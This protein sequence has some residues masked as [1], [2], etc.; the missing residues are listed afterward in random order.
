M[1]RAWWLDWQVSQAIT[2]SCCG[3]C[4]LVTTQLCPA[5][6]FSGQVNQ[7]PSLKKKI[8]IMSKFFLP[9]W[10]WRIWSLLA[11]ASLWH[12][13]VWSDWRMQKMVPVWTVVESVQ[14][15]GTGSSSGLWSP[16]CFLLID[17]WVFV[18]CNLLYFS[19]LKLV[20]SFLLCLQQRRCERTQRAV[21]CLHEPHWWKCDKL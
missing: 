13:L 8:R 14:P 20:S 7:K 15:A 10:I 9:T 16:V 1:F 12:E 17:F 6:G 11:A 4:L 2:L 18:C 19:R 21:S 5:F 3:C